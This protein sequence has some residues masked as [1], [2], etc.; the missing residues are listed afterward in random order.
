MMHISAFDSYRL[1]KSPIHLLNARIKVIITVL[2][3]LSNVLLSDGAWLA[4]LGSWLFILAISA[5]SRLG[6]GYAFKRSFV[7]LPFALVALTTLFSVPGPALATLH[8]ASWKLVVTEPGLVRFLT[9]LLRSWLS[10]Q[11][12]ILL[13]ATTQFPDVLHALRHLYVP[14]VLVSI[15]S[16]M[17]RYLFVLSD[18]ALRLLRA[19]ESRSARAVGPKSPLSVAR[20]AHQAGNLAGQLFLRSYERSDRIYNAMQARGYYGTLFTLHPHQMQAKDWL[21]GA[22]GLVLLAILQLVGHFLP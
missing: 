16:F 13:V 4:F 9:I 12:A 18:E 10:V 8:L 1:R 19:R 17:Y 15:I 21:I 7:A 22:I 20:E 2:F 6:I 5:F 11:M 3:I 14:G